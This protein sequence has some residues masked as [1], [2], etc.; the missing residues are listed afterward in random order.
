M[1]NNGSLLTKKEFAERCG[2]T[3]SN[4]AVY[5]LPKNGKIVYSG[6]R[7]NPNIEPNKSFLEKWREKNKVKLE[8]GEDSV[9]NKLREKSSFALKEPRVEFKDTSADIKPVS[10]YA[11]LELELKQSQ[12]RQALEN[13]KKLRIAN[14]RH[15]G[16]SIPADHV[17]LLLIQLSESIHLAWENEWDDFV[18]K[19]A[20]KNQMTRDE[21]SELKQMKIEIVN[22]SRSKAIQTA[23]TN[24]RRL[25]KETANKR[26]VG[27]HG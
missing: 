11:R 23:K 26:G 25:Q 21:V 7:V 24:L 9:N 1:A 10:E 3:T 4:L 2:M 17:K 22:N 20:A 16:N 27:E 18:L 19:I 12:V 15:S 8:L 13:E 5:A 14:E 6:D